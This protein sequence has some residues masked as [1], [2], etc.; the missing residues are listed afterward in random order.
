MYKIK[1][2]KGFTLVECVVAMA[3]L[4][5]MSLLLMMMLTVT[6]NAR[7]NNRNLENDIDRQV[8]LLAGV[9]ADTAAYTSQIAF[10]GPDGTGTFTEIIPAKGEIDASDGQPYN[11]DAEKYYDS[12]A[13]AALGVIKYDFSNYK[14]FVEIKNGGGTTNPPPPVSGT[15]KMYGSEKAQITISESVVD[16]SGEKTVTWTVSYTPATIAKEMSVKVV[17]PAGWHDLSFSN[18]SASR[19]LLIEDNTVRIGSEDSSITASM[20]FT[21]SDD[22][23]TAYGGLDKY[24][25]NGTGTGNSININL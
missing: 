4:A 8:D 6:I 14:K 1:S 21:I 10:E 12:A 7:N 15:G 19:M 9:G 16:G 17:L 20:T 11:I 5:I 13:D 18:T 2:K 25:K 24:F 22:S 23:Y 3:V